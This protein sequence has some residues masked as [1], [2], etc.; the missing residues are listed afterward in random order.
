MS[1]SR[2]SLRTAIMIVA[3]V[4]AIAAPI[5]RNVASAQSPQDNKPSP[6]ETK[7]IQSLSGPALY[8]AYCASCHG[9]DLK[10]GGPAA[11]ALKAKPA[12]LTR[13]AQRSGGKF[14]SARIQKIISGEEVVQGSHGSREMPIW[15][16]IFSQVAWD[17]D[18][19]KVRVYNLAKYLE[20][21]Q[22]K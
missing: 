17:Q 11:S 15:G 16:P 22:G 9:K 21:M 7:L 1:S 5:A 20:T 12:D 10:G 19:G 18:L 14:P 6:E 2:K 4:L 8:Q 3:A 13:I